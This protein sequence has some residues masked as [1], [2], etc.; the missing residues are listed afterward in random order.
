MASLNLDA[1]PDMDPNPQHG[2]F[3]PSSAGILRGFFFSSDIYFG[4]V[5][6]LLEVNLTIFWDW[7]PLEFSTSDLSTWSL[8][9]FVNY[10]SGFPTPALVPSIVSALS[11]C[12]GKSCPTVFTCLCLQSW[13]QRFA[14]GSPLSYGSQE[15]CCVFILF[16]FLLVVGMEWPLP[17]S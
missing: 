11:L 16:S 5:V 3:F 6:E 15:S 17:S 2:S 4:N 13:G 7:V 14:L 9:Q 1:N 10:G 12:S 8:Q